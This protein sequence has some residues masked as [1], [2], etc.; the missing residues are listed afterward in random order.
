[1]DPYTILINLGLTALQTFLGGIK[2][3]GKAPVEVVA[4]V[5]AAVDA[6]AAHKDDLVTKANLEAQRG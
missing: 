4:A 2:S 1:M 6:V 3:I 5:Q